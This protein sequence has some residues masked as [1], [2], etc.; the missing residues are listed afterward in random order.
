MLSIGILRGDGAAYYLRSVASGAEDY[1]VGRGEAPGRW[2][3]RLANELG[4]EGR[5]DGRELGEVLDGRDPASGDRLSRSRHR[6]VPG[7]DLTF[8]A[9]KSVSVLWALSDHDVARIVRDAHRVAVDAAIGY[10]E[11]AACWSRRGTNGVIQVA[12]TGFVGAGF[13]HRTS[14]SGDPHLH[15][16]VVVAN[17]TR[18]DDGWG[19]LDGRHL[20]LHAKTAGYLYQAQLRNELT[21]R[22]GV[23]WTPVRHGYAEIVGV[24]KTVLALFATRSDEIKQEMAARGVTSA[25]AAQYAALQTRRAKDHDLD[26]AFLS[27]RWAEQAAAVGFHADD[28]RELLGR[29]TPEPLTQHQLATIHAELVGGDGLTRQASTFDRRDVLRAWCDQL[30]EGADA[31]MI[32]EL[33]DRILADPAVA[34]LRADGQ[35]PTRTLRSHATGKP[36]DTPSMGTRYSTHQ[37]LALETR[38]IRRASVPSTTAGVADEDAVLTALAARPGL[39]PEQVEMV[40]TL[41]TSGRAVDVVVA[42][43]GTG[44]TFSLDAARDAWQLFAPHRHRLRALGSSCCRARDHRRNPQQH[45]RRPAARPR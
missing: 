28:V 1:Y 40:A 44:K 37:L 23:E 2:L 21:R 5:V 8:C 4:L 15:T 38:L 20:F 18:S 42:A 30:T 43:A 31:G 11:R 14:R 26:P 22:L 36:I 19:T 16:H 41:T 10:L 29:I 45:H 7:F 24:P 27:R 35:V 32:E 25:R 34:A 33:A 3:G 17:A 12:G 9:P 39:S 6:R 13:R